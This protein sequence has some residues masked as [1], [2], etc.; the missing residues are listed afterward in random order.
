M[1]H[2]ARIVVKMYQ[3]TRKARS[4]FKIFYLLSPHAIFLLL[5]LHIFPILKLFYKHLSLFVLL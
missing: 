4:L 2:Q 5:M 3:K 1:S